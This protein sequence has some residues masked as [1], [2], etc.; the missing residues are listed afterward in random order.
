MATNGR[1]ICDVVVVGASAGGVTAL[2][3]LFASLRDYRGVIAAVLHRSPHFV[4]D[5]P[6]VLA[7]YR[8]EVAVRVSEPAHGEAVLAGRIYV[9]PRDHHLAIRDGRFAVTR[10]AKEHYTRPAV[11][12]LLRTAAET[13]G[14]RVV[15]VLLTGCG[16]DGTL[17]LIRVKALGGV[18]IVQDPAEAPYPWM[19][20]NALVKD[21]VDRV[22]PLHEIAPALLEL[23]GDDA[24][25]ACSSAGRTATSSSRR[26][27]NGSSA[28]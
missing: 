1:P 14:S 28:A 15:G 20:L 2:Q 5:L 8:R 11:D 27:G 6:S 3:S 9:A 26:P 10:D 18:S 17:G 13:Y 23:Y 19:P 4:T 21:H 24:A 22:L 16:E 25:P 12:V 7:R